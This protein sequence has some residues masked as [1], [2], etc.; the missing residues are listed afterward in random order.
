MNCY[1]IPYLLLNWNFVESCLHCTFVSDKVVYNMWSLLLNCF[2]PLTFVLLSFIEFLTKF[3]QNSNY[4]TQILLTKHKHRA[5]YSINIPTIS[6]QPLWRVH[7]I[8]RN[9][10]EEENWWI[11]VLK[12]RR[13]GYQIWF[14]LRLSKR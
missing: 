11:S 3:M 6:L 14:W 4:P 10:K 2:W 9:L 7:H 1:W 8:F 5:P 12:S 13:R